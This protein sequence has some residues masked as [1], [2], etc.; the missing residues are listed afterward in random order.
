MWHGKKTTKIC[1]LNSSGLKLFPNKYSDCQCTLYSPL[2]KL[3]SF[4]RLCIS[5]CNGKRRLNNIKSTDKRM[6]E[7]KIYIY[8]Y[9]VKSR[10]STWDGL[11]S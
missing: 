6:N 7:C 8:I 3:F 4:L 5:P 9:I 1:T 10:L 11:Q 2:L